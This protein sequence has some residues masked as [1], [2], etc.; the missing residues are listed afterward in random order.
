MPRYERK[1][2]DK[3]VNTN[4]GNSKYDEAAAIAAIR[5]HHGLVTHAARQLKVNEYTL[6]RWISQEPE[7]H[8][9]REQAR[10]SVKDMA[11]KNL[12]AAIEN[13]A[14]WAIAMYLKTVGKDRGYVERQEIA[15][16]TD[17]PITVNINR[18]MRRG[19]D[20]ASN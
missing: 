16:T 10:E 14:P 8:A 15:G 19:G 9:A 3:R 17:A 1:M 20:T 13:G 12:F 6:H 2:Q 18:T 11:E 7:L 5:K 4:H